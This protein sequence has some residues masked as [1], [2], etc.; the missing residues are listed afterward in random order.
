MMKTVSSRFW[1]VYAI[2]IPFLIMLFA[3]ACNL[4]EQHEA[5]N[6][7][8][9]FVGVIVVAAWGVFVACVWSLP[10]ILM[11]AMTYRLFKGFK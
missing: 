4:V 3:W 5:M 8:E 1:L 10:L 11:V 6:I 9:A 2:L 7:G